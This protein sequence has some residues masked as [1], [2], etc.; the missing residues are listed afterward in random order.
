[1]QKET[2][3]AVY[4]IRLRSTEGTARVAVGNFPGRDAVEALKAAFDAHP[5][6]FARLESWRVE[7]RRMD[8]VS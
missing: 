7:M 4:F 6:L 2:E 5:H 3:Q 1:M 8:P